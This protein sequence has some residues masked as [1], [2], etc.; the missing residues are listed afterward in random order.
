MMMNGKD[1]SMIKTQIENSP[2]ILFD[3]S[4]LFLR[5]I[6]KEDLELL[7]RLFCDMEIMRYLGGKRIH[8]QHVAP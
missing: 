4:R 8:D 6:E 3:S 2:D 5:R 7:K 1:K